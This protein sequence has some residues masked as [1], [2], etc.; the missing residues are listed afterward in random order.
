MKTLKDESRIEVLYEILSVVANDLEQM[1]LMVYQ[2][3]VGII[4]D[5]GP[6]KKK[7]LLPP[8]R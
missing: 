5:S 7:F 8:C 2:S 4:L 1:I 6:L 3:V